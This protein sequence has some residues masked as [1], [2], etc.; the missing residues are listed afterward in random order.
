MECEVRKSVASF[1]PDEF[2]RSTKRRRSSKLEPN[3]AN[4]KTPFSRIVQMCSTRERSTS[5]VQEKLSDFGYSDIESKEALE[6]AVECGLID[7]SRF[8]DAYIRTKIAMGKGQRYIENELLK[9]DID[10]NALPDWP[11]GYGFSFDNELERALAYLRMHPSR[12][13][14]PWASSNRKLVQKGY[15]YSVA[16]EAVRI[17]FSD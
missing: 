7:D 3:I 16:N 14:N 4:Q 9:R 6:R 1:C 2:R 12:S 15:S 13:K 10:V 8:A 17:F 11:D 5:E